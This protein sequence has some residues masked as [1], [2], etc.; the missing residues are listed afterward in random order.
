MVTLPKLLYILQNTY[1]KIPDNI[2]NTINSEL[3]ALLGDGGHPRVALQ[4]M[5]CGQY[6]GGIA[7]PDI[8]AYYRAAHLIA[9]NEWF[10]APGDHPTYALERLQ[11][12]KSSYLH[13]L[14]VGAGTQSLLPTTQRATEA[15]KGGEKQMR[16]DKKLTKA[17]PLWE[18]RRLP[19][20]MKP[21]GFKG[22]NMVGITSLG[23]IIKKGELITFAELQADYQLTH[24]QQYNIYNYNMLEERKSLT[25]WTSQNTHH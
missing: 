14:Y 15:W 22:W 5:Q 2:F 16:W 11:F 9:T 13:Y 23:D 12:Q 21:Q 6:N 24:K 7:L 17:T 18:G 3:Q 25:Y 10:H 4:T 1:H 19:E 8:Q 20:L